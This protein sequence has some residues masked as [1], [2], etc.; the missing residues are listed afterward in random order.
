MTPAAHAHA[1]IADREA[2]EDRRNRLLDAF[3]VL[4]ESL[5]DNGFEVQLRARFARIMPPE[6][7]G[8]LPLTTILT[9]LQDADR[10]RLGAEA[11][12]RNR[13]ARDLVLSMMGAPS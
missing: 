2:D 3:D 11:K 10:C 9:A 4:V 6:A 13:R 8:S 12:L 5:K 7:V 1:A